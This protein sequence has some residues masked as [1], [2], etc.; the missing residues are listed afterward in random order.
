MY[1]KIGEKY[2]DIG[3]TTTVR[4][5]NSS[6]LNKFKSGRLKYTSAGSLEEARNIER[7]PSE[8]VKATEPSV[9]AGA[10]ERKEWT[11]YSILASGETDTHIFRGTESQFRNWLSESGREDWT[12]TPPKAP[13]TEKMDEI[14][15]WVATQK[16]TYMTERFPFDTREE[17]IEQGVALYGEENR[18]FLVDTIYRELRTPDE[19]A[20]QPPGYDVYGEPRDP[21]QDLIDL[22]DKIWQQKPTIDPFEWT[23]EDTATIRAE[24][25]EL[26]GPYYASQVAV[27]QRGAREAIGALEEAETRAIRRAEHNLE[28]ALTS[29]RAAMR[30]RGLAFSG[31]REEEERK[32]KE[33]STEEMQRVRDIATRGRR[34]ELMGLE[35]QIGSEAIR[36]LYPGY[37]ITSDGLYGTIPSEREMGWHQELARREAEA[38]QAYLSDIL[39]GES[40]SI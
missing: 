16:P 40:Y 31:I 25:E 14:L 11:A 33:I 36:G 8:E 27:A 26:Y 17:M 21:Y 30:S 1:Y 23:D 19:P 39:V 22:I 12:T 38:R 37:Q 10:G 4:V 15:N 18:Q 5:T 24:F 34:G 3:A 2:Y 7:K 28:E 29:S 32:T 20:Y 13:T 9:G 35:T 6:L